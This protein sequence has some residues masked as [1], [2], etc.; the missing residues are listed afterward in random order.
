[1]SAAPTKRQLLDEIKALKAELRECR[2][3]TGRLLDDLIEVLA[4]AHEPQRR[5]AQKTNALKRVRTTIRYVK[6]QQV[7]LT[8]PRRHR[9][10]V[11]RYRDRIALLAYASATTVK[12]ALSPK[13][14]LYLPLKPTK[15]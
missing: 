3:L 11:E 6:V 8:N 5:G 2:E 15:R 7:A 14:F 9:E 13:P 10:S 4:L 1:M 12:R